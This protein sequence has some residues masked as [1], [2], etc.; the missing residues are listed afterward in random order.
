MQ[1]CQNFES[2]LFVADDCDVS[3]YKHLSSVIPSRI[4]L[5]LKDSFSRH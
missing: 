2:A 5:T 1:H 3:C 4:Y